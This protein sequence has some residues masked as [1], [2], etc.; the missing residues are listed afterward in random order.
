M[1][2]A[3]LRGAQLGR[4]CN[5][6][7]RLAAACGRGLVVLSLEPRQ[8]ALCPRRCVVPYVL[9][10]AGVSAPRT[11]L[12]CPSAARANDVFRWSTR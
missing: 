3:V 11:V 5:G 9:G 4:W 10:P 1:T 8:S 2:S 12:S 6:A 7:Q